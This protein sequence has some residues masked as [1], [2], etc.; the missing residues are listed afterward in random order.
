MLSSCSSPSTSPPRLRNEKAVIRSS[1][2]EN[3]EKLFAEEERI[4]REGQ[5]VSSQVYYM[6]QTV[7]NACGTVALLHAILNS[8]NRLPIRQESFL[9][10]FYNRTM[11]MTPMER[12]KFLE[13]PKEG[14]PDIERA[15]QVE[16]SLNAGLR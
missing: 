1:L 3:A 7:G 6:K 14:D 9:S 4:E 2:F 15:H 5:S 10:R 11:E 8:M 13:D 16:A 12:A